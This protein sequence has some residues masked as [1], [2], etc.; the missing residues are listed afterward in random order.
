MGNVIASPIGCITWMKSRSFCWVQCICLFFN[1]GVKQK[2]RWA[3]RPTS[4]I[5][6]RSITLLLTTGR[7]ISSLHIS[8]TK[9][10]AETIRA[11]LTQR[12]RPYK[13]S[14]VH[15]NV[16]ETSGE[17]SQSSLLAIVEALY[18]VLNCA[19]NTF[20]ISSIARTICTKHCTTPLHC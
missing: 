18:N 11:L 19:H 4:K 5:I 14:H 3:T 1:Y 7:Q 10:E 9:H 15:I 2:I 17:R 13:M 20:T 6:I 16:K 12:L 8:S